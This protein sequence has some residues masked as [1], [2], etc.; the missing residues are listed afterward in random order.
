M[1]LVGKSAVITGAVGGI[2]FATAT[3]YLKEGVKVNPNEIHSY[4]NSMALL[5]FL[6]F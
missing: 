1:A 6:N 2:G 5:Q 4:C 3:H